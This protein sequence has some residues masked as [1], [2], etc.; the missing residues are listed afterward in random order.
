MVVN[1]Y[2][3]FLTKRISFKSIA[4][5]LAPTDLRLLKMLQFFDVLS[6]QTRPQSL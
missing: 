4:S 6:P 2:T 1:D 3:C 5:K